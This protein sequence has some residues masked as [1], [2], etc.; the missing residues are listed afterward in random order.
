[1]CPGGI[2]RAFLTILG[3]QRYT[4]LSLMYVI[5]LSTVKKVAELK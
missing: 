2:I 3:Y 4:A 5:M 1:M